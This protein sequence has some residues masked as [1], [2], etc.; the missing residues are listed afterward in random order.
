M[1]AQA[2][3]DTAPERALRSAMHRLG[4]RYRVHRRPI[5]MIRREADVIFTRERVAVFVDGC[6]WHACSQHGSR[7]RAN[8]VWWGDKLE[9]NVRRDRE[10]DR[11]L[12]DAG[13]E[14]V[15]VW[16]HEDPQQAAKSVAAAVSARRQRPI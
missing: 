14:P 2:E 7:P 5:P 10:T 6:F 8:A 11:M 12:R 13:W 9:A 15:R 1:A 4:L 3:R 16:E